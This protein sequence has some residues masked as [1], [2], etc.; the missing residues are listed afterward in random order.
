MNLR[1]LLKPKM[2]DYDTRGISNYIKNIAKPA[3]HL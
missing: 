1:Q 2:N 3:R